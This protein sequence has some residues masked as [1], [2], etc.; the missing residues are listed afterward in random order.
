MEGTNKRAPG[1]RGAGGLHLPLDCGTDHTTSQ[2]YFGVPGGVDRRSAPLPVV[3]LAP[4]FGEDPGLDPSLKCPACGSEWLHRAAVDVY[5]CAEDAET[6]LHTSAGGGVSHVDSDMRGNPSKRRGGSN[7]IIDE[8]VAL[9]RQDLNR[10]LDLALN[11]WC[12]QRC[13]RG[14]FLRRP[15]NSGGAR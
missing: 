14:H 7:Y 11:R 4:L 3:A 8:P 9:Q 10:L 15:P 12:E 6:G 2:R 5:D 1:E 13:P